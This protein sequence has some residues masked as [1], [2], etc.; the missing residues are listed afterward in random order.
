MKNTNNKTTVKDAAKF[1]WG[2]KEFETALKTDREDVQSEICMISDSFA[3]NG[4]FMIYGP[5]A[6]DFEP[7]KNSRYSDLKHEQIKPVITPYMEAGTCAVVPRSMFGHLAAGHARKIYMAA[8]GRWFSFVS[9]DADHGEHVEDG[10]DMCDFFNLGGI[11][12]TFDG[13]EVEK[14]FKKFKVE[15]VEICRPS[16]GSDIMRFHFT[17][18]GSKFTAALLKCY[19][20]EEYGADF[21]DEAERL[22]EKWSRDEAERLQRAKVA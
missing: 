1:F 10:A 14:I 7:V 22:A 21:E 16:K 15:G 13:R 12:A 6:P 20:D 8:A 5:G 18:K 9:Y 17:F 4:S 19:R 2:K 3:T 11:K